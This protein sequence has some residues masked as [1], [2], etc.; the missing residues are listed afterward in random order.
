MRRH[1]D[2]N[3]PNGNLTANSATRRTNLA[4]DSIPGRR[5]PCHNMSRNYR[6]PTSLLT[7]APPARWSD[8]NQFSTQL[9]SS[10]A[11]TNSTAVSSSEQTAVGWN[12]QVDK[13]FPS[14]SQLDQEPYSPTS[15]DEEAL[16][17]A[18][19][20]YTLS[21]SQLSQS[22]SSPSQLTDLGSS[23]QIQDDQVPSPTSSSTTT[24]SHGP[25]F[26]QSSATTSEQDEGT[27]VSVQSSPDLV[28]RVTTPIALERR[29]GLVWRTLRAFC[30]FQ[31]T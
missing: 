17:E 3:R 9:S 11:C 1:N 28:G 21:Q 13:Q 18:W 22:Q 2:L 26:P 30:L 24:A 29:L 25:L 6:A 16:E 15:E 27:V 12:S 5:A 10:S 7:A 4:S 31:D 20:E 8:E 19:T 23:S 14:L